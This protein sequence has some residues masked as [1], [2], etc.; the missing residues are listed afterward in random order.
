MSTGTRSSTPIVI[1]LFFIIGL[2]SAVVFSISA[3]PNDDRKEQ[4]LTFVAMAYDAEM[5][6]TV[7]NSGVTI[8]SLGRGPLLA[9][10]VVFLPFRHEATYTRDDVAI[11]MTVSAV[12]PT[13]HALACWIEI[14]GKQVEGSRD[15]KYMD[16]PLPGSQAGLLIVTCIYPVGG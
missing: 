16:T 1:G 11:T 12:V 8:S 10:Q 9:E 13:G 15:E 5:S 14:G 3:G 6:Q 2:I 4:P 7:Q